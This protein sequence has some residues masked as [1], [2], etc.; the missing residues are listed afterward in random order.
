MAT[1]LRS[2][3]VQ[4]GMVNMKLGNTFMADNCTNKENVT[5]SAID[6][7]YLTKEMED[8]TK[9]SKLMKSATDHLPII[10]EITRK[11]YL[12]KGPKVVWKRSMKGFTKEKWNE[13]LARKRWEAI[14][15]TEDV[16][17]M[18]KILNKHI[19]E[20][21]DECAPVK[22]FKIQ[23][24]YKSGLKEDTIEMI[25]DRDKIRKKIG[26]ATEE[27]KKNLQIEYKKIRNSVTTKIRKD[28]IAHNEERIEKA[29][30]ENEIWKVVN[31]IIA[32]KSE[33]S[34][35]LNEAGKILEDKKEIAEVFNEFFV[36]KIE[37]LKKNIDKKYLEEP[38]EKLKKKMD[39]KN[40]KFTL[41]T[42]TEKKVRKAMLS[43]R[44][45]KSSGKDGISQEQIILATDTLVIPLTRLINT[46]ITTGEF[47]AEWK[48]AMV[49][50]LLKKG[51]AQKKENYRP[52]SCL[53][54]AS[55][56]MEQIVCYQITR[57][58]EVHGLLPDNQHGFRARR[59]TMTA[60]VS[61]QQDWTENCDNKNVTGILLWDLSAAYDTLSPKLLCDKLSIYGFD[62]LSCKWFESFLTGRSQ[63]VKIGKIMSSS[64]ALESG[65]PQGGI[66][67]PMI[68]TVYGA[69]LE[70][71]TKKSTIFSYADDTSSS[72]KAKTVEEVVRM[73]E[74]DAEQ[75]LKFMASNGLVANPTKTT[76]LVLNNRM[77]EEVKVKV[78]ESYITQEKTTKL[79]GVNIDDELGWKNQVYGKGGVISTLNQRTHLIK[80]LR[81]HINAEK[82]KKIVDSLWTSKL[83][84]GLQLWA[85]V[86][87]IEAQPES[88]LVRDVQKVQ[89]R[90]LRIMERKRI[91][92]RT[93]VKDMLERQK[94]L[95]VNQTV[96]Q[97]K[98]TEVWKARHT[99]EYPLK[100]TFQVTKEGGRETRGDRSGKAVETGRTSKA[101]AT[102]MSDAARVWN[103]A[104]ESIRN[105]KTMMA[106][107]KAIKTFCKTLPV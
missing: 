2:A 89:N 104:P 87:T 19:Q 24:N 53:I 82:L 95:S 36:E 85:K 71:W 52:V 69:E 3:V 78:G 15:E 43:L 86:R 48:E 25:K 35:K 81:N 45:K 10:A 54:V 92:D 83:R 60:L 13:S 68:F 67:S 1:E 91:S 73:L 33:T 102:F 14:G 98:L 47:P 9:V 8:R 56:V 75:I 41:K 93:V 57:Y 55:K 80:R 21:L 26:K 7:I 74:E 84:Y 44:K 5:E 40:L 20:A 63:C 16:S 39:N 62:R 46:S 31:D 72:C 70:E 94:M 76:L 97:I 42:V 96:A 88:G 51:D 90:L 11:E 106:A 50:P 101:K 77:E 23:K 99:E 34:W 28:T 27:E 49:T 79:L 6:H 59:S 4:N 58:F 105:A 100:F 37:K 12:K 38:L 29:N 18:A 107:K 22:K 103:T 66:L 32:P 30:D 64:K 65:V 61:M 17:E